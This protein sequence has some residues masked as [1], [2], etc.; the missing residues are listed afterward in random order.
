[1]ARRKSAQIIPK[2]QPIRKSIVQASKVPT[3]RLPS[4]L[5]HMIFTYLEPAEAAA[6]RLV[7]KVVAEIGLQYLVPTAYLA[8]NEESY[9]RLL[10]IAEHPVVSK[11]VVKLEYEI[12]GLRL[13][14]RHEWDQQ[15]Q[16]L[17]EISSRDATSETPNRSASA[18]TWR[19]Y[20]QEFVRNLTLLNRRQT[21]SALNRAWLM[22][23]EYH[24]SQKRVQQAQFFPEKI[25]EAMKQLRNL[26][27]LSATADGAYKRYVAEMKKF[28]P[29]HYLLDSRQFGRSSIADTT[30]S[31][32]SAAESVDLRCQHFLSRFINLQIFGQINSN[33]A[34]L[35]NSM[36]HL[37]TMKLGFTVIRGGR[38]IHSIKID[39]VEKGCVLNFVTS[40]P[41]LQ[42]LRLAFDTL[43]DFFLE[44]QFNKT[45]GCFHW[46]FLKAV[47]LVGLYSHEYELWIFFG[48]HARTLKHVSLK[49]M[50]Q[51][52]RSW[53]KT[54]QEMR[55][56]FAF[57]QQLNTCR[58]T[59][60]FSSPTHIIEDIEDTVVSDYVQATD[61]EDISLDEYCEIIGIPPIEPASRS[62]R[63]IGW[64]GVNQ[65]KE[66]LVFSCSYLMWRCYRGSI[67]C[68][69]STSKHPLPNYRN[70]KMA[71]PMM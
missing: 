56:E 53:H 17:S 26:K 32:L 21:T 1:M 68:W 43:C 9:D 3:E 37:E 65:S 47:S 40:A 50:H 19:A 61:F 30:S 27:T 18:R 63:H 38:E 59:G 34:S 57:G 35:K 25:A 11:Y 71:T 22:Y 10:A 52:E 4:E 42:H 54:F 29:T 16:S 58:L 48:T 69:R 13:I 2:K 62:P 6:F 20:D 70:Y 55:R 28:L 14:S 5:I 31:I 15:I 7:G 49:N 33:F 66:V 8:L 67:T 23:E 39:I 41:N 46:P 64:H 45:I 60:Y 44:I 24:A 51:Y 36:L 12:E